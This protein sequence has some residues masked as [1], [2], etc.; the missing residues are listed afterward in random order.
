MFAGWRSDIV[1]LQSVQG[2]WRLIC[3]WGYCIIPHLF[4]FLNRRTDGQTHTQIHMERSAWEGRNKVWKAKPPHILTLK[5]TLKVKMN[6]YMNVAAS[7]FIPLET[8]T[9]CGLSWYNWI[10]RLWY[11]HMMGWWAGCIH[12]SCHN[13]D[14]AYVCL[15]R[16][17][18]P[19]VRPHAM[20][21]HLYILDKVD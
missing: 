1:H 20:W 13:R 7:L 21:L 4:A 8:G 14:E 5:Y 2:C 16:R 10:D 17:R 9:H 12:G 3:T 11:S 15:A 6:G 18:R 19:Y